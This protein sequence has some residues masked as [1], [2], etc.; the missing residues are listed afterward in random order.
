LNTYQTAAGLEVRGDDQNSVV[1]D[2]RT[3]I[4]TLNVTDENVKRIFSQLIPLCFL[5]SIINF[6][7]QEGRMG[8]ITNSILLNYY[9]NEPLRPRTPAELELDQQLEAYNQSLNAKPVY[10]HEVSLLREHESECE[11]NDDENVFSDEDVGDD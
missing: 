3:I 2:S 7:T 6:E 1:F 10:N 9:F 8:I 11:E 4:P 5:K